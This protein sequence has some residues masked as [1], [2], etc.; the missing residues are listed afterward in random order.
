MPFT[1][2]KSSKNLR[3]RPV[4]SFIYICQATWPD[5]TD[6]R[7]KLLTCLT[8]AFLFFNI[9]FGQT[10]AKVWSLEECVNYALENNIQVRTNAMQTRINKNN[11]EAAWWNYS[12][13]VSANSNSGWNF[14][15]NI[16]PV[17]NQI[18]ETRRF[19]SSL[20][21]GAQ[22]VLYDGGRK[23]NSIAQNNHQ[24]LASLYDLER[25]SNDV[26]LNVASAYLQVL[27]NREILSVAEEQ[28][29]ISDLQVKRTGK[30]VDAGSAPKGDLLQFEAQQARDEQNAV[31]A[32]NS[33]LISKLQ[34][35]NL[36]QLANPDDFEVADPQLEVP[37]PVLLTTSPSRIFG[38]AVENQPGILAAEERIKSS[39]EAVDWSQGG[40]WPTLSLQGQVGSSYSDQIKEAT[41]TNEI[42]IP[43]PVYDN[44]GDVI[45]I[46]QNQVV[47]SDFRNKAFSDQLSDNINEYFGF[48]LNVPIFNRMQVKNNVQNAIIQ[49]EI[50]QLQLEQEKNSLR[51]VI[52]QAHA[53]AKASYNSYLAAQK[54]VDASQESFKYAD[55]RFQ[56]GAINQFDYE[57]AKNSLAVAKSE[58]LR[59][60]YDFI[61]KIKVLEFY[62]TNEVK[63]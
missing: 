15:L 60:K 59:A 31:A 52:Y 48:S 26:R 37:E 63:L 30:L 7:M 14:G 6:F 41:V 24:Y 44:N 23:Y 5:Q 55:E 8:A 36:L 49:R 43:V 40:Y 2:S 32:R 11:L 50:S 45:F 13:G 19:T 21:I 53:D 17:T 62:L 54:A 57:N 16:D 47:P 22:W 56:V 18:S 34:L 4:G 38:T 29:K 35:A 42:N 51:Q 61:F 28:L 39:E 9:S 46:Q 27:L 12:P 25:I 3:H 1:A 58:M 20:S 33:L 10:P